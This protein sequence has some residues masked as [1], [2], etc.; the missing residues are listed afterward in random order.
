MTAT[1][2]AG[3][4]VGIDKPVPD[5]TLK[6]LDGEEIQ[7]SDFK[8]KFVVLEW[9]SFD[10]PFV[11]KHYK[12]G[13]MQALQKKYGEKGVVWLVINSSAKGKAGHYPVEVLKE[14]LERNKVEATLTCL[15]NADFLCFLDFI[16]Y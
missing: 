11:G 13:N 5:F 8:G 9:N 2:L 1:L 4:D 7:L 3:P 15:M 10:C 16:K 12:K 14:K 6:N